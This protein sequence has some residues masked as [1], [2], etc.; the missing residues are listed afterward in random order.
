MASDAFGYRARAVHTH[1]PLL[2]TACY[3]D[4]SAELRRLHELRHGQEV[5]LHWWHACEVQHYPP[6]FDRVPELPGV[7]PP[8]RIVPC[9]AQGCLR[10]REGRAGFQFPWI[11]PYTRRSV[12]VEEGTTPADAWARASAV[13]DRLSEDE[14]M[15]AWSGLTID[16]ILPTHLNRLV[17]IISM[18]DGLRLADADCL[19]QVVRTWQCGERRW[20]E[21]AF[22]PVASRAVALRDAV[23]RAGQTLWLWLGLLQTDVEELHPPCAACGMPTVLLCGRCGNF[24]CRDCLAPCLSCN[25]P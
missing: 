1:R 13:Q 11:G 19:W 9:V 17:L 23:A 24:L 7:L 16:E 21:P 15:A 3:M 25:P 18:Q 4:W 8:V 14:V 20:R 5:L 2:A 6:H 12:L 22:E 10:C